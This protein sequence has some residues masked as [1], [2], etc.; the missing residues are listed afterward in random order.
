MKGAGNDIYLK[1]LKKF[2]DIVKS[3]KTDYFYAD[4]AVQ[5]QEIIDKIYAEKQN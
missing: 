3:G 2:T 1:Q 4:R 5:V